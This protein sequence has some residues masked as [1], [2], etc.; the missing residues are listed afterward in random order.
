M[1]RLFRY[2]PPLV[3]SLVL[4]E[5]SLRVLGYPLWKRPGTL[6][7]RLEFTEEDPVIGNRNKSGR[8]EYL[9][10]E[11]R[12]QITIWPD[13]QR[14]S[15]PLEAQGGNE[16]LMLGD[17]FAFGF[18]LSDSETP[19]WLLQEL[20]PEKNVINLGTPGYGTLHAMLALEQYLDAHPSE[21]VTEVTYLFNLFHERRNIGDVYSLRIFKPASETKT[22]VVPIATL[23]PQQ[24]PVVVYIPMEPIWW[25][26]KWTHIG[27]I[28]EDGVKFIERLD[29]VQKARSVTIALLERMNEICRAR[30]ARFSVVFVDIEDDA[31]AEYEKA[32]R[33]K[34]IAFID[35]KAEHYGSPQY[36]ISDGHPTGAL[37]RLIAKAIRDFV[38]SQQVVQHQRSD[39]HSAE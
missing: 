13:H 19:A 35:T 5:I 33:Q 3:F 36:R 7:S 11:R 14:A 21:E 6:V 30:G 2:I 12:F 39:S 28:I 24:R 15:K 8:Y 17:S 37:N 38:T 22:H 23:N 34:D 1:K 26:S 18:G 32:L 16:L 10:G 4:A 20:L 29:R 31:Q 9:D 27:A 25:I